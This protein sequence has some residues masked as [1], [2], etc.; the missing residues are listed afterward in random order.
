[1]SEI[2]T[3]EDAATPEKAVKEIEERVSADSRGG[4]RL[5]KF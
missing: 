2:A 4:T 1:M 3:S 5:P